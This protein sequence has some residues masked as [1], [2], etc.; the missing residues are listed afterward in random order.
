M[1]KPTQADLVA[2]PHVTMTA[3]CYWDPAC[4]DSD[5][6]YDPVTP[7]E[8]D[9]YPDECYHDTT[10][11]E[12]VANSSKVHKAPKSIMPA[13]PNFESLRKFFNWVDVDR[14]RKTL[15]HTTQFFRAARQNRLKRHYKTRFPAA[16]VHRLNEDVSTDTLM[17]DVPAHDDGIPGHGG[18]TKAQLFTGIKS[19]L[20]ELFPLKDESE[21]YKSVQE[22][23]RKRGAPNNLKSDNAKAI[24]GQMT[25]EILLQYKIGSKY[26]ETGQQNQN[27]AE[28]TI[29]DIKADTAKCMDR[30]GTP[31]KYW[32]ICMLHIV[33]LYNML[34]F[35]SLGGKTPIEV[36][37]DVMPDISPVLTYCW[38]QP[39]Y[40]L[41]DDG[42]FPLDT[43]EKRGRWCGVAE[44]IGDTLT[45]WILTNDTKKLIVQ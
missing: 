8:Y 27:K 5:A 16:N 17:S 1:T 28:H 39:I 22:F 9:T 12:V 2:Y 14:V 6:F 18:C 3:D 30:T 20:T 25:K 44:N 40:Y 41:D 29:Q 33:Y 21:I 23:L 37:T 36:A 31:A 35:L 7:D 15:E 42:K 10:D 24:Y 34:S 43:K 38:W 13:K 45:Y 11:G 32:L 26:S 4:H 19:H